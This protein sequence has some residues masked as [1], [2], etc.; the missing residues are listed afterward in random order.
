MRRRSN[1]HLTDSFHVF[2]A[3]VVS[4]PAVLARTRAQAAGALLSSVKGRGGNSGAF[5]SLSRIAA[6]GIA[7]TRQNSICRT[8]RVGDMKVVHF[9]KYYPHRL[10]SLIVGGASPYNRI[11]ASE[12]HFLLDLYEQGLA[13]GVEA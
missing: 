6:A 11:R 2:S 10:R 5:V 4:A 1:A 7:S 3:L 9:A 12:S 13:K 8:E